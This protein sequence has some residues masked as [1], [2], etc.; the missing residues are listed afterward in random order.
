MNNH[1]CQKVQKVYFGSFGSFHDFTLFIP[2]QFI[3]D[4][5]HITYSFT[6]DAGQEDLL[7]HHI[8]DIFS[9]T[10]L[11]S[12]DCKLQTIRITNSWASHIQLPMSKDFCPQP[13]TNLLQ[14]LT[15]DMN[16]VIIDC[17]IVKLFVHTLRL[18][19]SGRKCKFHRKLSSLPL[20]GIFIR[21]WDENYPRDKNSSV[22]ST[23]DTLENFV[24]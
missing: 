2:F 7:V 5:L 19:Y 17:Y 22:A 8:R 20:K 21:F 13:H 14:G 1:I 6:L 18:I 9:S 3:F 23:Y 11:I 24:V 15:W 4:I 10:I 12:L 16:F